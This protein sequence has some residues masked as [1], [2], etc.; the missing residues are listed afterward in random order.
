LARFIN[1]TKSAVILPKVLIALA[2]AM[3]FGWISNAFAGTI[4]SVWIAV[5]LAQML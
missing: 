2:Y 1:L 4:A 5:C 3:I